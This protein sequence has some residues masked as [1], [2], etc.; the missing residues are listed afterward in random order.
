VKSIRLICLAMILALAFSP[1]FCGQ[2]RTYELFGGYSYDRHGNTSLNGW[3]AALT[4]NLTDQIG[5]T[6]DLSGHY[7]SGE[8]DFAEEHKVDGQARLHSFRAGPQFTARF[9]GSG[10]AVFGN[11]LLGATRYYLSGRPAGGR[12]SPGQ[13]SETG[14]SLAAGAGLDVRVT[15]TVSIR[16]FQVHFDSF[17]RDGRDF[18]EGMRVSFGVVIR[19]H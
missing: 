2:R 11:V 7:M 12:G 3:N 17:K 1:I 8:Y 16:A 15:E 10:N 9:L 5:V 14:F 19:S 6:A 18:D 13:V 4:R